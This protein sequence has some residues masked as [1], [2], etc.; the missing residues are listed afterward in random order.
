MLSVTFDP[1]VNLAAMCPTLA[2]AGGLC[3]HSGTVPERM[4]AGRRGLGWQV[5]TDANII[6]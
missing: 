3:S 1:C 5:A 2:P 4:V 6:A